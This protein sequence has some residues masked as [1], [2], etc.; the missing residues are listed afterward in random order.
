MRSALVA[1]AIAAV[2]AALA[3]AA[4]LW[5][6]R[7]DAAA[8]PAARGVTVSVYFTRG[9][10]GPSCRRVLARPR[11]VVAPGV[12]R[13]A[14]R[15]LLRGP[16]AAERRLGY[17]G[18]FSARTQGKLRSVRIAGGVAYVD[19]HD[20]RRTI[21]NASTSCGSALLLAQLDRTV[22]QFPTVRRGV[23]SLDGDRAA[24]YEW[25]GRSAPRG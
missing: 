18:W 17:G 25:L 20:L 6:G 11:D 22:T 5:D 3:G 24:F 8:A 9:D 12:L 7:D 16:T 2:A 10:P 4:V 14:L 15:E 23:Y 19:L 1:G 13:G 21:P